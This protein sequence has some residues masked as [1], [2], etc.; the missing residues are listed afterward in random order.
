MQPKTWLIGLFVC[1]AL[2][3]AHESAVAQSRTCDAGAGMFSVPPGPAATATDRLEGTIWFLPSSV[4]NQ[5][6]DVLVTV[7]V[8]D[9]MDPLLRS[10]SK[11]G[12]LP[13]N[14]V[15]RVQWTRDELDKLFD[16]SSSSFGAR[17]RLTTPR[18]LKKPV[19]F[20]PGQ[21]K[22]GDNFPEESVAL[23]YSK[24]EWKYVEQDDGSGK[25]NVATTYD[26]KPSECKED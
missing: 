21:T 18:P 9:L 10:D 15:V 24:V 6:T 13:S 7:E 26:V 3:L 5:L 2:L 14:G 8:F 12:P 25:G 11:K 19:L 22:P 4:L 16:P 20:G 23:N 1:V 17:I